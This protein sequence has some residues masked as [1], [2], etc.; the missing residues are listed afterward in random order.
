MKYR[1]YIGFKI[2]NF[3]NTEI[4]LIEANRKDEANFA[5]KYVKCCII[6]PRKRQMVRMQKIF[7]EN[8]FTFFGVE[9]I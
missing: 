1:E 9:C 7:L 2:Q 4:K 3:H 5:P 6:Y 8:G